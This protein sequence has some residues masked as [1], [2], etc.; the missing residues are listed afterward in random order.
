MSR[1]CCLLLVVLLAGCSS[2]KPERFLPESVTADAIVASTAIDETH[3]SSIQE[4]VNAAPQEGGWTIG[5]AP[6]EYYER[7]VIDKPGITLIGAG[8][9]QTKIVF[10]RYAGKAVTRGSEE[11]WGTSRSATV[12]IT[13]PGVHIANLT[14]ENGF[15]FL[16]EDA[17]ESSDPARVSGMQAV[18]LKISE[19]T[20]KTFIKNVALLGYQ[21]TLYVRGGRSYFKG[22]EIRG[23]VDFIFGDG[24]AYFDNVSIYSRPRGKDMDITGYI[25]APSTLISDTFGLTFVNCK[26]LREE[27]VPDNS[28]PLGRPWHPTT[29]FDDG[30]YANPFAIGK[31]VFINTWM[32]AHITTTGWASMGGSTKE[33]GRKEFDPINDARF[34]E[35]GSS[36]PGYAIN[37]QRPQLGVEKMDIYKRFNILNG[38]EPELTTTPK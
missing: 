21:D 29:T 9:D 7:V 22:G 24:N 31:A 6:G 13:R 8:M 14:I 28:V 16:T 35:Y 27:G 5:V 20:D 26:L 23:N 11:H 36:G 32:D 10:D 2:E 37:E 15:D 25:T 1:I 33:G 12:E 34:A 38:W 17:R 30:R 19:Y 18:A 4:A 3:Y